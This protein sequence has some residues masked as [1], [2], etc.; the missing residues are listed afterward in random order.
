MAPRLSVVVASHERPLRLRWLLNALEEQTLDRSLWEVVVGEDSAAPETAELLRTHPLAEAG[1]LRHVHLEPGTGTPG[2]NRNAALRLAEAPTIVFTDD[3]CRPP[4]E[5]LETVH[6]AVERNPGAIIQGRVEGDP[7][8]SAMRHSPYPRSQFFA[9]VPRPWAECC[10]IVYPR[11]YVDRVGGFLEDLYHGE[12]MDL[13]LRVRAE[14]GAP[15]IG[16]EDMLTYHAVE[17]GWLLTR[18]RAAQAWR[19]LVLFVKRHPESRQNFAL[20]IFWKRT[21]FWL[22]VA[23]LGA[24]LE[25]RNPLWAVLIVPW[26]VQW[27]PRHGGIRG[28]LRH[29][30]ELPGLAAIDAAEMV[31]MARGSVRYRTPML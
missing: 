13:N 29:L 11:E 10:N 8:E 28:R 20:G 3:D 16:D 2:A 23:L 12:D 17:E 22:L 14:T 6:A 15:Y 5:W 7:I 30:I 31:S 21:H 4:P 19:D 26:A 9:K 27:Q 24:K 18:M 1:M 25:R